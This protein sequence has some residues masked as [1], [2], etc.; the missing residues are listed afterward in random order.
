MLISKLEEGSVDKEKLIQKGSTEHMR[1]QQM[2]NQSCQ[3]SRNTGVGIISAKLKR[4]LDQISRHFL[5][6]AEGIF[7]FTQFSSLKFVPAIGCIAIIRVCLGMLGRHHQY[8]VITLLQVNRV[9]F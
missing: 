8:Q 9:P 3:H 6:A 1:E 4:D 2:E 5:G 7:G